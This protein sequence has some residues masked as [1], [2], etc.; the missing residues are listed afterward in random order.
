M[1]DH[2]KVDNISRKK[3]AKYLKTIFIELAE[4][5]IGKIEK[6]FSKIHY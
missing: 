1:G 5:E 3:T 4:I 6:K 2:I